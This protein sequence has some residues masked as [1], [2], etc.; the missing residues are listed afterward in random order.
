MSIGKQTPGVEL[1]WMLQDAQVSDKALAQA[2]VVE[3]FPGLYAFA[4]ELTKDPDHALAHSEKVLALSEKVLA[5]AVR[6]RGRIQVRSSLRAWLYEKVY[7]ESAAAPGWRRRGEGKG[8]GADDLPLSL[9]CGHGLLEEEIGEALGLPVKEVLERIGRGYL[10]AYRRFFLGEAPGEDHLPYLLPLLLPG[11]LRE[12]QTG[13]PVSGLAHR[14]R[15]AA[16]RTFVKMLPAL[17]KRLAEEYAPQQAPESSLALREVLEKAGVEGSLGRRFPLREMALVG[18]VLLGV[19]YFG[20]AQDVLTPY[21]ARVTP[22]RTPRPATAT[23]VSLPPPA[24][25]GVEN[26]DYF[27]FRYNPHPGETLET[28]AEL[29]G[30]TVD[31]LRGLDGLA[32][33]GEPQKGGS[34]RLVKFTEP[35]ETL[36]LPAPLPPALDLDSSIDELVERMRSS[37]RWYRTLQVDEAWIDH[38][39]PSYR[40]PPVEVLRYRSWVGGDGREVLYISSPGSPELAPQAYYYENP[41]KFVY[42]PTAGLFYINHDENEPFARASERGLGVFELDPS[43]WKIEEMGEVAGRLAVAVAVYVNEFGGI[44]RMWVDAVTGIDL[45]FEVWGARGEDGRALIREK[46]VVEL[47][48]DGEIPNEIFVPVG[49]DGSEPVVFRAAPAPL[50]MEGY[51]VK[52]PIAEKLQ[53]P[54]GFELA[55]QRLTFQR[56]EAHQSALEVYAGGFFLGSLEL[57]GKSLRACRRS[58]S[59]RDA[60]L[61]IG[62]AL[63]MDV[64]GQLFHLSLEPLRLTP[65]TEA[66]NKEIAF[67]FAPDGMRLAYIPCQSGTCRV[68]L[69][70][71]ASGEQRE[72]A[73]LSASYS[74]GAIWWEEDGREVRFVHSAVEGTFLVGIEVESGEIVTRRPYDPEQEEALPAPTVDD[75]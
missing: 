5:E 46:R 65:L 68:M 57:E 66:F 56:S 22:S 15:C 54:P 42:N 74:T 52:Q 75:C 25:A 29:V 71:L 51:V 31:E 73:D 8:G 9:W 53:P 58:A 35:E 2:L 64:I 27:F 11:S 17:E 41:W 3:Y 19:I 59:G 61:M 4:H 13:L 72:L 70:D 55:G 44:D 1:A 12:E 21:D 43:T 67:G 39:I 23:P 47:I 38:S 62:P 6:G 7:R 48:L 30:L 14:E 49:P 18:I 32:A 34:V 60:A 36:Y 50:D 63:R 33:E 37:R 20:R 40:G 10:E 28:L 16:C 24:L 45:G 69:L 26:R